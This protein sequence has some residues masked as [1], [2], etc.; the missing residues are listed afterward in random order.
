MATTWVMVADKSRA[1]LFASDA[2][3][4]QLADIGAFEHAE[5]RAH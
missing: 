2:N 5:G 1:R 4:E 3:D